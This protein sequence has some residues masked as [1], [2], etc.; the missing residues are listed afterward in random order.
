[1]TMQRILQEPKYAI[2]SASA[3][4]NTTIVPAVSGKAIRVLGYTLVTDAAVGVKLA[5]TGS[6]NLDLTGVMPLSANGGAAPNDG[7]GG[8]GLM[9]TSKGHALVLNLN[10]TANVGGHIT[11]IEV[12]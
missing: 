1:M 5:Q 11:Y 10:G 4:G 2:I 12:G 6:S 3:S 7:G 9:Q 8:W